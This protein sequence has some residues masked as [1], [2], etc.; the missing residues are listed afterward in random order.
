MLLLHQLVHMRARA[1]TN[2]LQHGAVAE[3]A[4]RVEANQTGGDGPPASSEPLP[5]QGMAA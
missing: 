5:E 1:L 4:A 2:V 3:V